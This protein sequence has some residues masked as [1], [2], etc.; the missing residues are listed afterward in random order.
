MV[1]QITFIMCEVRER[2]EGQN[3]RK[4]ESIVY[5]DKSSFYI[6]TLNTIRSIASRASTGLNIANG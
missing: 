5:A 3:P 1:D 2:G 4:T 6:Y